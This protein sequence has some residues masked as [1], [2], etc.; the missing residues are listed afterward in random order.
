VYIHPFRQRNQVHRKLEQVL[1]A[2]C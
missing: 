1:E 2:Q